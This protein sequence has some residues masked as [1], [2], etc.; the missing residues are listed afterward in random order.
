MLW[1]RTQALAPDARFE[2]PVFTKKGTFTLVATVAGRETLV[3]K[4]GTFDCWRVQVRTAFDGK[5][6]AKRDTFLWYSADE[7]QVPVR[8]SAEFS[9]GSIVVHLAGYRAGG[10]LAKN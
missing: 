10:Q 9:V 3:T 4:A 2:I 7:N 6:E 1:L 5:F 8:I